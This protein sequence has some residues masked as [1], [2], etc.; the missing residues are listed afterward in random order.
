MSLVKSV[1][2]IGGLTLVSRILGFV[3]DILIAARLGA[4]LYADVFFVAFKLPNFFRSL[5]AE[6]AFSSAFVP[7]FSG[8]LSAEGKAPARIFADKVF[9]VLLLVLIAFTIIMELAMPLIMHGL[10]P[11]FAENKEKFDLAV[12][13]TR[14]TMPYL[15]CMS[16]VSL[17][18][19]M[20]NSIGKFWAMAASPILLNLCMVLAIL[21]LTHITLTPAHALS[22]GVTIA[23]IV[24]LVAIAISLYRSGLMV[25]FRMPAGDS[26]VMEM[27][28][29]MIPGIVGSGIVQINLWVDTIIATWLPHGSVSLLYYADRV[30]QLP[31]AIIG[32]AMGTALLP[33]L[34]KQLRAGD[35][36][37]AHRTQNRA[38]EFSLLLALPCTV[39][40]ITFAS[41]LIEVLFQRG[42]FHAQETAGS[43][44]ALIAFAVG[45]PAFIMVKNFAPCFFAVHDT[46]TPVK[47][48]VSCMLL[49]I[50]FNVILMHFLAH[51]G[52]A[53]AT[54]L[55]AWI[56]VT[57]LS[58]TLHKRGLFQIDR[59]LKRRFPRMLI[60]CAAMAVVL[61]AGNHYWHDALR[62]LPIGKILT[63]CLLISAGGMTFLIVGHILKA[64]EVT[65]V[66][67]LLRRRATITK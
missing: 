56:N 52:I 65:E 10:A 63:F 31:L 11:G 8:M 25:R 45:L 19:G 32:T 15:L 40:L 13:L 12:A 34:S 17:F 42:V 58:T 21:Y 14:V 30:N 3:R 4:G 46:K 33:L 29:N 5:F 41:P 37:A 6:G 24:Q 66:K 57:L 28:K 9:T 38:L 18:G 49:N 60:A 55:S 61:C 47:F 36:D 53:L 7:I 20:L 35:R 1:A 44:A 59:Q 16:L 27:L 39:A 64:F 23:G 43:A 48:A 54:S 67:G 62:L 22:W 26:S 50:I 51:V 2:V